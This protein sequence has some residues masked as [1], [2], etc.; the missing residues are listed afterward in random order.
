MKK[1]K[2]V[3]SE[4]IKEKMKSLSPKERKELKDAMQKVARNPYIGEPIGGGLKIKLL[5]K[6][7]WFWREIE[8]LFER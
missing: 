6:I 1:F 4:Q 3:M 7:K 5:N 8:I 2:I